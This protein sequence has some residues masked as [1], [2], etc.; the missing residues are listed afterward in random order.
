MFILIRNKSSMNCSCLW[1][2]AKLRVGGPSPAARTKNKYNNQNTAGTYLLDP[3]VQNTD[4]GT[5]Q[6]VSH[7]QGTADTLLKDICENPSTN[8][9]EVLINVNDDKE[10]DKPTEP[11][12][13]V[14][15]EKHLA[16]DQFNPTN[17][18]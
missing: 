7:V 4:F 5:C 17:T 8:A 2:S 11:D 14:D 10:P 9:D 12:K 15:P 16:E 6:L 18:D 3:H 1:S 13:N